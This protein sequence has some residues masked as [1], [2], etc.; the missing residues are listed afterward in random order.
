[1]MFFQKFDILTFLLYLF[2]AC[3][4]V[5]FIKL[6]Y[7]S[8]GIK[9]LS[10]KKRSL[11]IYI[12][13]V[14]TLLTIFASVRN[15]S[16]GGLGGI[17]AEYY[18]YQFSS[19]KGNLYHFLD[20]SKIITF[21][22]REPLYYI[23]IHLVRCFTTD[24]HIWFFLLYGIIV[25]GFLYFILNFM[26]RDAAFI[27]VLIPLCNYLHSFNVMRNWIAIAI[28]AIAIVKLSK[29]KELQYL[30]F[31]MIA[32]GFHYS[33]LIMLVFYAY[34]KMF[35]TIPL[36]KVNLLSSVIAINLI[37]TSIGSLIAYL[38][39]DNKFRFYIGLESSGIGYLTTI[40]IWLL[41]LLLFDK[42]IKRRE[43]NRLF[44]IGLSLNVGFMYAIVNMGAY[45]I[46]D[47][48]S[49]FKMY[50]L[51][52]CICIVKSQY[53]G[54]VGKLLLAIL[55]IFI[56]LYVVQLF[57]NYVNASGIMPYQFGGI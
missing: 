49:L 36:I 53:R 14:W 54:S 47:F 7:S 21:N 42:L 57:V 39:N 18:V 51:S 13:A 41:T 4:V 25:Y 29:K 37:T 24:Y 26:K 38:F 44:I 46:N 45:R 6:S 1:M 20:W 11:N 50:I 2:I 27:V 19:Y 23:S 5:F 10:L 3:F 43:V 30:I 34:Y 16:S 40:F 52:E 33:A 31:V 22:V 56:I 48:F 12:F 28:I 8:K 17:D 32:A 55:Y 15:V 35:N 9:Y